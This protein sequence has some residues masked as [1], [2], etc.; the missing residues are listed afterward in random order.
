MQLALL[1]QTVDSQ[2]KELEEV[3]ELFRKVRACVHAC[4]SE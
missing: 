1:V 2:H 3:K 4:M